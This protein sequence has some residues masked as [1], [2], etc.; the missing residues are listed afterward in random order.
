MPKLFETNAAYW[1]LILVYIFVGSSTGSTIT[2]LVLSSLRPLRA[3]PETAVTGGL[4][5]F[6]FKWLKEQITQRWRDQNM[7]RCNRIW[8]SCGIST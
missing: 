2:H 3:R 5:Q 4:K 1:L 7:N 8:T 6:S